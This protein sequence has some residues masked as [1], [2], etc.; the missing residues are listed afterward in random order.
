MPIT[1]NKIATLPDQPDVEVNKFEW[2]EDHI[3]LT[4]SLVATVTVGGITAGTDLSNINYDTLLQQLLAPYASPA[5]SSFT[6]SGQA[7]SIEVG[8]T[9][10]GSKNFAFS[11]TNGANVSPNTLAIFDVTAATFLVTG[12]PTTSPQAASIGSVTLSSPGTYSWRG[13]ATNTNTINFSSAPFTVSWLWRLYYGTSTNTTLTEA[14]IEAL[15]NNSL[16]AVNTAIYPFIA[17]GYKYF[18][19]ADSLG[20]PTTSTGFK[21]TSNNL[22]VSMA[23]SVDDAF[24]SNVQNGWSYGLVSV[25]N[26]NGVVTNY[27][28][29]RTK[30]Q[31]GG[32]INI[33]VS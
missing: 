15:T 22:P 10:T 24:F 28:V 32:S 1:H 31:L 33:Q 25:T 20:S 29:Y 21:D 23:S 30:N 3:A 18:A 4:G 16:V 19:W 14:Q 27:R 12:A 26:A 2:N 5:F 7:T 8:T 6:M 17:G 9:L 11:F 13:Q